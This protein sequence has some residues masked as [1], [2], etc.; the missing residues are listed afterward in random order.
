MH[1][2]VEAFAVEHEPGHE[3]LEL[4]C[5]E[6]DVE[7][8]DGMRAAR[9]IGQNPRLDFELADDRIAQFFGDRPSRGIEID[10]SVIALVLDHGVLLF[11][12][13]S[14]FWTAHSAR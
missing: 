11:L 1:E 9:L 4:R 13:H 12:W 10:V 8:G 5:F 2:N 3:L 6:D 7:L 14:S